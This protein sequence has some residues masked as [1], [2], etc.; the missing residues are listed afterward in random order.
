M[1]TNFWRPRREKEEEEKA[2]R[3]CHVLLIVF[4]ELFVHSAVLGLSTADKRSSV[5]LS[6]LSVCL[7]PSL[8]SL[9]LPPPALT[10]P[11]SLFYLSPSLCLY[12]SPPLSPISLYPSLSPSLSPISVS[13]PPLSL[14]LPPVSLSL[15][16]G[17]LKR[18]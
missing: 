15:P 5:C 8:S 17:L 4:G 7:S 18:H 1:E 16:F 14:S 12:L 2:G 13:L 6:V 9:C 3:E 11:P 10:L